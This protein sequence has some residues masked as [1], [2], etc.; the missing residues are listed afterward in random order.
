MEP[1]MEPNAKKSKTELRDELRNELRNELR[2]EL[3][4]LT[5][6]VVPGDLSARPDGAVL[7]LRTLPG[8]APGHIGTL[9]TELDAEG[10]YT[11]QVDPPNA[12]HPLVLPVIA[13]LPIEG[14]A[15]E[16]VKTMQAA[17]CLMHN[18][19][20]SVAETYRQVKWTV[21]ACLLSSEGMTFKQTART[22][23][24]ACAFLTAS[25]TSDFL[26]LIDAR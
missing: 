24:R 13:A 3:A 10:D 1:N 7:L 20:H 2:E 18:F 23:V 6:R 26:S 19:P 22:Y 4:A 12:P 21:F 25:E 14:V 5:A 15:P 9:S 16:D 11:L 8:L 17:V